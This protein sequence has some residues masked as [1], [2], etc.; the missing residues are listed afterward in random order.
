M[1]NSA[2]NDDHEFVTY[3]EFR[4]FVTETRTGFVH[5]ESKI[6]WLQSTMNIRFEAIDKRF[7]DFTANINK[8]FD[9][10]T[11]N[12]NKRFE[13]FTANINKRFDDHTANINKRFEE[14]TA[15]INKRFDDLNKRFDDSNAKS[16][17]EF[18]GIMLGFLSINLVIIG[19]VV[20]LIAKTG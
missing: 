11:A 16:H 7:D 4:G 20:G 3:S 12:I 2:G 17:R 19:S 1:N 10:H 14:F 18:V 5:L 15:N 6:D 13:E 9:D 8:R